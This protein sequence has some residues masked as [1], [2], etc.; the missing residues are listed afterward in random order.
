LEDNKWGN[1][2]PEIE[3]SFITLKSELLW[4]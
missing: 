2:N 4:K 3:D 1:Q